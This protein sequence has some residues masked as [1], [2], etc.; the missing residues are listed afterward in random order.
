M[1]K[2][3]GQGSN[4]S[5]SCW[6]TPQPQ[7][8]WIWTMS[9]AYT[10]AHDNAGSLTHSARPWIELLS[11]WILV[12]FVT[13]EPR[14]ELPLLVLTNKSWV[15]GVRNRMWI[16]VKKL[17]QQKQQN[18]PYWCMVRSVGRKP[19]SFSWGKPL[20][21]G[22]CFIQTLSTYSQTSKKGKSSERGLGQYFIASI[23]F[24]FDEVRRN[25]LR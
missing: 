7:Q 14:W 24:D 8:C 3:P 1:W 5:C 25:S 17:Q 16:L 13:K 12:W 19:Y 10:T 9:G 6:P 11:S 2:F 15:C 23:E 22:L 20:N 21:H 18:T 4:Q